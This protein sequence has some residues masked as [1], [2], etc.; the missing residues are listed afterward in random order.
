MST[1]RMISSFIIV[2]LLSCSSINYLASEEIIEG[3]QNN[4]SL[5]GKLYI[6]G[7]IT[8][9]GYILKAY[10]ADGTLRG[11]CDISEFS[12]NDEFSYYIMILST[13]TEPIHFFIDN[14]I[15]S[16]SI[17]TPL[18]NPLEIEY[19]DKEILFKADLALEVDLSTSNYFVD[20]NE[21]TIQLLTNSI[22]TLYAGS[23]VMVKWS[24]TNAKFSDEI[25]ISMKRS[26][27]SEIV[28]IPDNINWYR[29]TDHYANGQ[30]DGE[31][32]IIVPRNLQEASDWRLFVRHKKSN[33]WDSSDD[34]FKYSNGNPQLEQ[35]ISDQLLTIETLNATISSML[36]EEQCNHQIESAIFEKNVIISTMKT[37]DELNKA[38]NVAVSKVENEKNKIIEQKNQLIAS[39]FTLSQHE[40]AIENALS[41]LKSETDEIINLKNQIIASMFTF[42]ELEQAIEN[43]VSIAESEKDKQCHSFIIN[44]RLIERSKWDINMDNKKGLFE[45]IDALKT[46]SETFEND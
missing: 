40:L 33:K 28:S 23:S 9:E 30:N 45:A 41:A 29:F 36:T 16:Y 22:T 26:S 20:P 12:D 4:M 43:A 7:H 32:E 39:M 8:H 27:L 25:I 18:P 42:E 6:N 3:Y 11:I 31:E 2:I 10:A 15:L 24:T 13:Q 5:F 21:V 37:Q 35:I 19:S 1:K 44:E 14:T 34:R 38:I 17:K 46:C